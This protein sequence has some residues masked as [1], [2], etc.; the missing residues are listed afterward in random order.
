[1]ALVSVSQAARLAGIS[2]Q[3]LHRKYI[4]TGQISVSQGVKGEP[5]IETS[6]ILRVFGA[7][8]GDT[9]GGVKE[10]QEATPYNDSENSALVAE[11]Q[12][13]LQAVETENRALRGRIEDKDRHLDDMRQ[14]MR[15]LEDQR[16]RKRWWW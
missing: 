1:M 10:L 13:R 2:R 16:P 6:E 9:P 3:H 14:V 8:K 12:A 7:L 4:K 11:L 15:L 5:L